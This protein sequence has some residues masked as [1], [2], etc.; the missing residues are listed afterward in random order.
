MSVRGDVEVYEK[1]SSLKDGKYA[2]FNMV[3]NVFSLAVCFPVFGCV[4][5]SS[6]LELWLAGS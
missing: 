5:Q 2:N 1:L 3:V 6:C 4:L